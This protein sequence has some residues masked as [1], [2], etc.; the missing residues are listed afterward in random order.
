L[1]FL[2]EIFQILIQTI[3]GWPDL[4][5]AT[6]NWPDL[7]QKFLTRTHY[8]LKL[9]KKNLKGWFDPLFSPPCAW[10]RKKVIKYS[11]KIFFIVVSFT[12]KVKTFVFHL[13]RTTCSKLGPRPHQRQYFSKVPS[14]KLFSK[15]SLKIQ[16]TLNHT[17]LAKKILFIFYQAFIKNSMIQM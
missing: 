12:G 7:G 1:T 9:S 14:F 11:L 6:K 10:L 16:S 8:F 4:T 15:N 5:R 17:L 3:N 13:Q 2:G